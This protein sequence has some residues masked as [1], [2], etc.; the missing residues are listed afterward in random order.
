M[1]TE[2]AQIQ[3]YLAEQAA[4]IEKELADSLPSD[5]KVP[6]PLRE[7]MM[8][9]LLAGGK[10]LRPVM[11]LEAAK[12]LGGDEKAA[13][14]VA[15]AVEMIHTY[16]LIH[17]DLP[18]MDNDDYRRGKLTNHKVYGEAMAILAGDA[19][20]THAFYS[21]VQAYRTHGVSAESVA[22]IVEELSRL[23]GA[24]GMVGG[25]AADM[26]G[27]QGLTSLEQ[28][29]YIH[30]HKTSDLIVF[31][32]KAGGRIASASKEQL[33]ALERFGSNLGLAF[34]I[35][36]DILDLVGDEQKLGKPVQSDVK[37]QKVTYPFFI[38]IEASKAKVEELTRQA[39]QAI[40]EASFPHPER[41]LQIA[42]FLMRRDH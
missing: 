7:A 40:I 38:G 1:S 36:D 19:L 9:S 42:D 14:P 4:L 23:A 28:L 2:T 12:A 29:E 18:A 6:A 21:I 25:Q 30:Y 5:W 24:Q 39:K 41:L 37:Q 16:S 10:R 34:Q 26:E 3:T 8:Y 13:L 22:D 32:L 20:L 15:L 31:S 27:E 17:D 11:V 35:Q 33:A